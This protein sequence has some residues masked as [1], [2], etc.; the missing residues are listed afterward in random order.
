MAFLFV[1]AVIVAVLLQAT[2]GAPADYDPTTPLYLDAY[3]ATP[4]L[5]TQGRNLSLVPSLPEQAALPFVLHSGF[6]TVVS[7]CSLFFE[8]FSPPSASPL[9][10][11][12]FLAGGPGLAGSYW[13]LY[14]GLTPLRFVH[15]ADPP[16]LSFE[17]SWASDAHVLVIDFPTAVGYSQCLTDPWTA[18]NVSA[19]TA[20]LL[21]FM[22][23][24]FVL[25]PELVQGEVFIAGHSYGGRNAPDLAAA[26]QAAR[27]PVAGCII[28]SGLSQAYLSFSETCSAI[29][30][31]G[32]FSRSGYGACNASLEAIR[33]A[34]VAKDAVGAER[35]VSSAMNLIRASNNRYAYQDFQRAFAF[36][37]QDA[38]VALLVSPAM[39]LALHV[40]TTSYAALTPYPYTDQWSGESLTGLD[41]VLRADGRGRVLYF[42]SNTDSLHGASTQ[43]LLGALDYS[44]RTGWGEKTRAQPLTV[45]R[46]PATRGFVKADDRL[47]FAM[48]YDASHEISIVQPQLSRQLVADFVRGD[49]PG[50]QQPADVVDSSAA[51][52][53]RRSMLVPRRASSTS[54]RGAQS[55]D[56]VSEAVY[57]TPYLGLANGPQLAQQLSAV[58]LP[59]SSPL[60]ANGT[61]SGYITV[62]DAEDSNSF[63]WF[64]PALDGNASAPLILHLSG[65]PG[66][67]SMAMGF[68]YQH[69]PFEVVQGSTD[70]LETRYRPDNYNEHAH[71]LYVDNPIGTGFSYTRDAKN[72]R[73]DS[74]QIAGDLYEFLRQF[75]LLF[76]VYRTSRLYVHGVSYAG[77]FLPTLGARIHMENA[78]RPVSEYMPFEGLFIASGWM[79]EP[80]QLSQ[81][82]DFYVGIGRMDLFDRRRLIGC[83]D[84]HCD[85][86]FYNYVWGDV[87]EAQEPAIMAYLTHPSVLSALHAG[88]RGLRI[89]S[90]NPAVNDALSNDPSVKPEVELLLASGA[91]RVLMYTA[92]YD[93]VCAASGVVNFISSLQYTNA[94]GWET[95]TRRT[96]RYLPLAT[97]PASQSRQPPHTAMGQPWDVQA[98]AIWWQHNDA[99]TL[100]YAMIRFAGHLIEQTHLYQAGHILSRIL[101]LPSLPKPSSSAG[102]DPNAPLLLDAYLNDSA[103]DAGRTLSLVTDLPPVYRYDNPTVPTTLPFTIHSGYF[104]VTPA[105]SLF[106]QLFSPAT[107]ADALP[108]IVFLAGGPGLAASWSTLYGG[109]GPL[110]LGR[111]A[112]VLMYHNESW[113][114]RAHVLIIDAP[115]GV[116]WSQCP[117][118]A[119][120][121]AESTTHLTT[122]MR[123]FV[124]LWPDLG[125]AEAF[126]AGHSY[127]A[128]FATELAAAMVRDGMRVAGVILEDGLLHAYWSHSATCEAAYQQALLTTTERLRCAELLDHLRAAVP[129]K[130]ESAA[131]AAANSLMALIG[132]SNGG[133]R[134]SV[135]DWQREFTFPQI[136]AEVAFITSAAMRRAFH[137]GNATAYTVHT[138]YAFSDLWSGESL[139]TL[140][141]LL[142]EDG[143][144]VLA[145]SS[146]KEVL[147]AASLQRTLNATVYS[148]RTGWST[149]GY[150]NAEALYVG[151]DT[152]TTRGLMKTDRAT[153]N[154]L[155]FAEVFNAG[156]GV[157]IIQPQLS[158][159]LVHSFI[160]AGGRGLHADQPLASLTAE[161]VAVPSEAELLEVPGTPDDARVPVEDLAQPVVSPAVYL[162]QYVG[163]ADG[164]LMAQR[165]A[166]VDL[167]QQ[168]VLQSNT[169]YSGYITIDADYSS[170]S[171]F[172]FLPALDGNASAPLILHLSGG[173]GISSM[174]MGFLY[175]HGPFQ[176]VQGSTDP[177]ATRYRPD[178]YNEHAHMLYVDNPIGTGYSFT[179][180]VRG[181]RTDSRQIAGDLYEFLRQFYLLFPVYRTSRLY[182]HGV[183]YAG[184]FLPTLGARIH[185][186]NARRP[187]S[188]YMPFEGLFIASGY[189]DPAVQNAQKDDFYVSIGRMDPANRTR[190]LIG[191]D[192]DSYNYVWGDVYPQQQ[193]AIMAYLNH[194]T[195]VSALHAGPRG[196]YIQSS[197]ASVSRALQP[198]DRPVKAEVELLLA[199]GAYRVMMYTA[200]YDVVCQASGVLSFIASLNYTNATGWEAATTKVWQPQPWRPE[201]QRRQ[202][203][204]TAWTQPWQSAPQAVW[205]KYRSDLTLSYAM[206]RFAGHLIEQTHLYQA[207][208]ILS[209]ILALPTLPK[210]PSAQ[211]TSSSSSAFPPTS[212]SS[213]LP[214]LPTSQPTPT[215]TP[216]STPLPPPGPTSAPMSSSSVLPP[217][218]ESSSTGH[219][220]A[221]EEDSTRGVWISLVLL[222]MF[223]VCI[224]TGAF[225][226]VRKERREAK[227]HRGTAVGRGDTLHT[228]LLADDEKEGN[229]RL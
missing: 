209:R 45:G 136:D 74:R 65:G 213:S 85:L 67:S 63:F 156:H 185:M 139:S 173:P 187:V 160:Q 97:R 111:N 82:T 58:N 1:I 103:R 150:A 202:P 178:N 183:S 21:T 87:W 224:G 84:A 157:S 109:V 64:L 23:S 17:E 153:R 49:R 123:K 71:V 165:A 114:E 24:F 76:P 37:N 93:V 69:G 144:R 176:V 110:V 39:R 42:A 73:T 70:P 90:F 193:T 147:H 188:E 180:D 164:P 92:E 29:Y 44:R 212:A 108:L 196:L 161:V 14:G 168:N 158:A 12:V 31:Q 98:Q 177:L 138:S 62:N 59:H 3:L 197:N 48:V 81:E 9:P 125:R 66:I 121:V 218:P 146:N 190:G 137:S 223:C 107:A 221:H 207:G 30:Q 127:G 116:G 115:V 26:M 20:Q 166:M 149:P 228:S 18:R 154:R 130:D 191:R 198:N 28:E 141:E 113:A 78:R 43:R 2:A 140:D 142:R 95:V 105:C 135:Y 217:P 68:L 112:S 215:G 163:A 182:V 133:P 199:S 56:P 35:G 16:R 86:D 72:L 80:S 152:R 220:P 129:A 101:D 122:F 119:R 159:E 7:D 83:D 99:L 189:M 225:F 13:S 203:P 5:R 32:R 131:S 100:T 38:M 55:A 57:L 148:Q 51:P 169:T 36:T 170:N 155:W 219:E 162:S 226:Q 145:F 194:P 151:G 79:D 227:E 47:W 117:Q 200:E 124:T 120:D 118:Q 214:F 210:P 186:E 181:I 205:W 172:W 52:P 25:F 8:L 89:E 40:G 53:A 229:A 167:P 175:Q 11:I 104:S 50:I 171:F 208:Q 27:L 222:L 96:E 128:R 195:V 206:I 75:Y 4:E 91:Y 41:D 132:T 10:L 201:A 204:H 184:H 61:Y 77:H 211:P 102:Y 15:G 134:N 60:R 94:T 19:A 126:I 192:L 216:T 33:V 106:F 174:A 46:D 179:N 143:Q 88:P 54:T 22:R 34:L 6:F